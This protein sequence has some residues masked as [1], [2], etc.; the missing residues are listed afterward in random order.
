MHF[1]SVVSTLV[2]VGVANAVVGPIKMTEN[3]YVHDPS[4]CKD[5]DGTYF[6][7]CKP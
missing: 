7:F 2:L 4:I 3:V 1:F 5:K 6:V